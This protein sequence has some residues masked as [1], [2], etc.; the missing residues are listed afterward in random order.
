VVCSLRPH[1]GIQAHH[2]DAD[3]VG[4]AA[5]AARRIGQDVSRKP[6]AKQCWS[7]RVLATDPFADDMGN[8]GDKTL[9][10]EIVIARA[11]GECMCCAQQIIPGTPTRRMA[12]LFDGIVA[13]YRYCFACCDAMAE[14]WTDGGDAWAAREELRY[15]AP[16]PGSAPSASR[17][18]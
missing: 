2:P 16:L 9:R 12:E 6:I 3:V 18:T 1:Q 5:A 4:T 7:E 17:S 14:S 15:R 10:N 8:V 13:S 11:A